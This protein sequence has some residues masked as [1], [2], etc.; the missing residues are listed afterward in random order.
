MWVSVSNS[1]FD[2]SKIKPLHSEDGSILTLLCHGSEKNPNYLEGSGDASST[3][4]VSCAE[5]TLDYD[6]ERASCTDR[7]E[8]G[9]TLTSYF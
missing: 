7:H 9:K 8:P 1:Q 2:S 3:V 6:V 5:G 4:D